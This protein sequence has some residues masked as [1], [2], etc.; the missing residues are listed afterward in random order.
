MA[1]RPRRWFG[2]LGLGS[3]PAAAEAGLLL[4]IAS[5]ASL[6]L[7]LSCLSMQSLTLQNARRLA[8]LSRLRQAEDSLMSAAQLLVATLQTR[9]ACLLPLAL[10]LWSGAGCVRAAELPGLTQGEVNAVPYQLLSWQP[11]AMSALSETSTGAELLLELRPP[12]GQPA[13][14]TAFAVVLQ[15]SPLRVR[16]LRLLGL[17][18]IAP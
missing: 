15:G 1:G 12:D 7:L 10:E 11:K 2:R 3:A 9:H 5:L 4:P 6:V 14:R 13:L 18:G 16:D 17:R 8:A